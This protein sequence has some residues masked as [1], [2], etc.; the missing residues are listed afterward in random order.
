[1][2]EPTKEAWDMW[3]GVEARVLEA[4]DVG[5][6][7][8][9]GQVRDLTKIEVLGGRCESHIEA[10]FYAWWEALKSANGLDWAH[11]VPQSEIEVDGSRFRIDYTVTM[12]VH[13]GSY[14]SEIFTA[15]PKIAIELD[16]HDFHERTKEQVTYRNK[17]D[18]ALQ[19]AG[20]KVFHISGS[21]LHRAPRECVRELLNHVFGEWMDFWKA[22]W[23]E[24]QILMD[25]RRLEPGNPH[26]A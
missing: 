26:G 25:S 8:F 2:A 10:V 21:E 6:A 19:A 22:Y 17:R 9:R 18:R 15:Y 24:V 4:A 11:L 20:W 3:H 7:L 13:P 14:G 12:D 23:A 5:A 1:M 16:G